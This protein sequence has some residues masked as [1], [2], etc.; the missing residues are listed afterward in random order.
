MIRIQHGA[1]RGILAAM[2]TQPID[3]EPDAPSLREVL[4]C[5]GIESSYDRARRKVQKRLAKMFIE[6]TETAIPG[7]EVTYLTLDP[8]LWKEMTV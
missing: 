1:T 4:A 2:N 5:K 6:Q 8:R 7:I 3:T